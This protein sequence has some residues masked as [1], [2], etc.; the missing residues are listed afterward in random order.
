MT[1][2]AFMPALFLFVVSLSAWS[3][4]NGL[5]RG[6]A[7]AKAERPSTGTKIVVGKVAEITR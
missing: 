4:D 3:Q 7:K 6:M 2:A 1:R 5:S